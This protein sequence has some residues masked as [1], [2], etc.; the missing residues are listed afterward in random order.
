[1]AP[2]AGRHGFSWSGSS[3]GW[4]CASANYQLHPARF[5]AQVI[6]AKRVIAWLHA[7]G[8]TCGADP[9]RLVLAGGS[10]GAHLAMT[11]AL[12]ANDPRFQ[13][14]FEEV[15]TRLVAAVGF[16]GFYGQVTEDVDSSPAGHVRPDAPPVLIIHGTHDPMA[17]V[18]DARH[19]AAT[20]RAVSAAVVM[21]AELPGGLHAF[22]RFASIRSAAVAAAVEAFGDAVVSGRTGE[23]TR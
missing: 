4:V 12:T 8:A 5:P 18:E 19:F 1:M 14:G 15:D 17:P 11:C 23:A 20:L 6:D 3:R 9:A 2:R 16:Y 21:L 13:P 22:D 7:E 10:A